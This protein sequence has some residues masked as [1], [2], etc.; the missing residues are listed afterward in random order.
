MEKF[1]TELSEVLLQ[2]YEAFIKILPQLGIS[3][4]VFLF[5]MVLA[6]SVKKSLRKFFSSKIED[7]LL[8]KFLA[9]IGRFIILVFGILIALNIVG[10][11]GT[12]A[13]LLAGAGV[14]AFIIGFAF[15]DIGENLLAGI[16][17]AF[18]R[19]FRTGDTVEIIGVT[20]SV[21]N[22]TLRNTH[23][24]TFDGKDVFIPN[25]AVLKNKLINF[26][27][28][29]FLRFEFALSLDQHDDVE[30]L[31]TLLL[32][33]FSNDEAILQ[34]N[35]APRVFLTDIDKYSRKLTAY[36]W[37][38]SFDP[39]TSPDEVRHQVFRNVIATLEKEGIYLPPDKIS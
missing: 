32:Q 11:G 2:Y 31:R 12:A 30:K 24:K 15:K 5:F 39:E 34:E 20:G 1:W 13:G 16:M 29:G 4:L 8:A 14:G 23:L 21:V 19:P 26:T 9:R 28:D 6:A 33:S 36:F 3:I 18:N 37:V 17:L 35:K 22:L 38:D 27:L 10:L 7:P 25:A